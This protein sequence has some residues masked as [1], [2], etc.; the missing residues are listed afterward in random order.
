MLGQVGV[1]KRFKSIRIIV[2]ILKDNVD[3]FRCIGGGIVKCLNCVCDQKVEV[4]DELL[5]KSIKGNSGSYCYVWS[6]GWCVC[7]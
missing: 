7:V 1:Q 3:G 6:G 5:D 4:V 2:P